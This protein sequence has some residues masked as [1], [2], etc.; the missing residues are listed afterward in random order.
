MRL[1]PLPKDHSLVSLRSP[2]LVTGTFKDP[3][4]RPD[5]K[6]L[7]LRGIAAAALGMIAPPAA[8]IPLFETGPGKNVDCGVAVAVK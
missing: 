2:L 3:E 4:F 8:L 5:M 1:K 6:R 7:T